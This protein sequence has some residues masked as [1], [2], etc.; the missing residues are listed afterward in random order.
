MALQLMAFVRSWERVL[1]Y[2]LRLWGSVTAFGYL[3]TSHI[4]LQVMHAW[5]QFVHMLVDAASE[6]SSEISGLCNPN[7]N[8][9][10]GIM[11]GD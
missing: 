4:K 8:D 2:K 5:K 3:G 11:V 7:P 1:R 6:S 10:K 9:P